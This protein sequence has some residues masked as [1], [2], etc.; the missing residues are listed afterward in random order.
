MENEVLHVGQSVASIIYDQLVFNGQNELMGKS[1]EHRTL[2]KEDGVWKIAFMTVL[3]G[4]GDS[5]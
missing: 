3:G 5:N 1:K 2:V 4:I